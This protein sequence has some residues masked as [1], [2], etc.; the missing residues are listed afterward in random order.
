MN[1]NKFDFWVEV[2]AWSIVFLGAF[3]LIKLIILIL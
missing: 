3:L 2:S 1:K